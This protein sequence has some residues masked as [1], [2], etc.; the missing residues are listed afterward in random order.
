MALVLG[1]NCGF[2]SVAPEADP[3]GTATTSDAYARAIKHIA[4]AGATAITEI[5]WWSDNNSVETNFEVG[6]YSHH[7]G[8]DK[9]DAR[10][11]VDDTNAKGTGS[12]WKTVAVNWEITEGTTYWIAIQIDQHTG[13]T[14]IDYQ[15]AGAPSRG[16]TVSAASLANPWT[17]GGFENAGY[18][19]SIYAV[20]TAGAGGVLVP[21]YYQKLLAG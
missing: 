8:N 21:H 20:Y 1:T 5:G 7:A 17:A 6:L 10:L 3:D 12:G 9:P 19:F 4:P 2:V 11:F 13:D 14:K 18:N 15:N 16:S